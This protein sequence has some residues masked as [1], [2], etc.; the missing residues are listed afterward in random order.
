MLPAIEAVQLH[1]APEKG[2]KYATDAKLRSDQRRLASLVGTIAIGLPIIVGLLGYWFG[3]FRSSISSYYYEVYLAGD[4]FVGFLVFIG[5]LMTAYRGWAGS[6]AWLATV[7]GL[8]SCVVAFFP[9]K[10]WVSDEQRW[11][12][13]NGLAP[14]IHG[15]AA[16]ALF[17]ILAFF[18]L[19]IFTD[20]NDTQHRDARNNLQSSKRL[21]NRIYKLSGWAI[22]LAIAAIFVGYIV[23]KVWAESVNLVYWGEFVA[24]IA[25]GISWLTHGRVFYKIEAVMDEKDRQAAR[26]M[27][28]AGATEN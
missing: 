14:V 15:L 27:A 28:A 1:Y 13:L 21:R 10:G 11:E 7:A 18:C 5:A 19:Y 12:F 24:L 16:L 8:L 25:F 20:I 6:V 9:T 2:Y 22:L 4:I 3:N 26:E 23:D 17:L